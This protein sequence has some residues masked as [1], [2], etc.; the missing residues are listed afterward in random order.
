[1]QSFSHVFWY[2]QRFSHVYNM[3]SF[4]QPAFCIEIVHIMFK[5]LQYIAFC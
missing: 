1:M 4:L 2:T 5:I 3:Q